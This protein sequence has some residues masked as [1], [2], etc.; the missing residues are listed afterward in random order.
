MALYEDEEKLPNMEIWEETSG[1][2][3]RREIL[4]PRTA[5]CY[6]TE[7]GI[8]HVLLPV[9]RSSSRSTSCQRGSM[10]HQYL[11]DTCAWHWILMIRII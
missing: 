6:D 7:E 2:A 3:V 5:G 4:S 9:G 1:K 11:D 8:P 10:Q